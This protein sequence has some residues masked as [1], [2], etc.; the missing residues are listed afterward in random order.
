MLRLDTAERAIETFERM[1]KLNV[2]IH[3]IAGNLT[4]FLKPNRFYH[5]SPLC[6]AVKAQG[7]LAACLHF[8]NVQL[9]RE[10]ASLP[11][12]RMHVCHANLVE[13]AVPVFERGELIWVIYAGPRS[14][15][16]DL[17][18]AVRARLIRW[19]KS[20]FA[21]RF[22][23]PEPVEEEEAQII[24]EHLRQ[25]AARLEKW[26][27]ESKLERLTAPLVSPNTQPADVT[28]T[29]I[30]TI[31]RFIEDSYQQTATLP[32]LAKK[33]GL[34]ESRT[35][36]YVKKACGRSFRELLVQRRLRAAMD[37]L[38]Q[39]DMSVLDVSLASGFEDVTH[40]H[41]LFRKRMGMTPAH[42]RFGGQS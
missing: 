26:V 28:T 18:S 9:R 10:I 29:R 3:D 11:D 22:S 31:H 33:L 36:H 1:H 41:R 35:S 16:K 20:P 7:Q 32:L 12:G 27:S 8:E 17:S 5:R 19:E 14:P 4:P 25:L 39:S 38:R 34:S 24:L 37:L 21:K 40:F 42:Y 2:T 6:F 15:G 13:W 23:L 30:V